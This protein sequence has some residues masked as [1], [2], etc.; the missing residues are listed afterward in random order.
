[1]R[2]LWVEKNNPLGF[3][4]FPITTK[5]KREGEGVERK[6]PS[7]RQVLRRNTG[8]RKFESEDEKLIDFHL[9]FFI[10][11]HKNIF[12][13]GKPFFSWGA[14]GLFV[15]GKKSSESLYNFNLHWMIGMSGCVVFTGFWA[16]NL[17]FQERGFY[18]ET[19]FDGNVDEM[20]F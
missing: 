5:E 12:K 16:E 7:L 20:K 9:F 6:S 2:V 11:V 4:L 10:C 17:N 15:Q 1:M 13:A 18:L 8:V 14:W 3:I 19:K